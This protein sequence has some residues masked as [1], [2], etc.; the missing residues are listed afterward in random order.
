[1]PKDPGT[2]NVQLQ[3]KAEDEAARLRRLRNNPVTVET[4]PEFSTLVETPRNTKDSLS[5][6]NNL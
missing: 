1:V 3:K 4:L 6:N 5:I 2:V